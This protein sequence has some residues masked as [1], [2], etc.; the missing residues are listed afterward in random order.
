MLGKNRLV[1]AIA[2]CVLVTVGCGDVTPD[3]HPTTAEIL[4]CRPVAN[5]LTRATEVNTDPWLKGMTFKGWAFTLPEYS[6]WCYDMNE[7]TCIAEAETFSAPGADSLWYSTSRNTWTS[8]QTVSIFG[9]SPVDGNYTF[10]RETGITVHDYDILSDIDLRYAVPSLDN[11]MN[12]H[13]YFVPMIF[14]HARCKVDLRVNTVG[15]QSKITIMRISLLNMAHTGDF[16]VD[17]EKWTINENN[18]I[19]RDF[20]I[21]DNGLSMTSQIVY[22]LE[23]KPLWCLPQDLKKTCFEVEYYVDLGNGFVMHRVLRTPLFSGKWDTGRHYTYN[24]NIRE[25]SVN[26]KDYDSYYEY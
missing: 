19:T 26:Y 11:S 5:Q 7:A 4:C 21:P 17:T 25:D 6:Y 20:E 10:D 12:T 8:K 18:L 13:T 3:L 2:A 9:I 23:D 15:A 16:S 1:S 24:L 14:K 22:S